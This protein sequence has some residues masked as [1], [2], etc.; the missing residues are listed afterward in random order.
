VEAAVKGDRDRFVAAELELRRELQL[1]PFRRLGL[2][3]YR[4]EA[5]EK[6]RMAAEASARVLAK[7]PGMEVR[8]PYPAP[9]FKLRGQHRYHLLLKSVQPAP[10]R[11]ALRSLD[12]KQSLPAGVIRVVD[13]DPQ[14]ML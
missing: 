11:A 9:F 14:S 8:G 5:E 7:E 4:A 1:P 3:T 2:L 12:T 10:L 6:A 13:L